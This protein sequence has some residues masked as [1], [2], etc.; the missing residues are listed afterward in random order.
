MST[1]GVASAGPHSD[2]PWHLSNNL[3]PRYIH[4]TINTTRCGGLASVNAPRMDC[5]FS[6]AKVSETRR[7]PRSRGPLPDV[8]SARSPTVHRKRS[9]L[10]S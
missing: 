2:Y 5:C 9:P 6:S 7:G 4:R 3:I 8:E 1:A 10:T